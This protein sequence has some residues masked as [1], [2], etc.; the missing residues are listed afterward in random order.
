MQIKQKY[1]FYKN[2]KRKIHVK[3]IRVV[4]T[5]VWEMEIEKNETSKWERPCMCNELSII[6]KS[7]LCIKGSEGLMG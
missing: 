5:G 4:T 3:Y 7:N 1:I 6:I 2:T